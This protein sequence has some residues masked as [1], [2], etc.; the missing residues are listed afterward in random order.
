MRALAAVALLILVSLRASA[1]DSRASSTSTSKQFIV[2]CED[3]AVRGRVTSFVEEV[4]EQVYELLDW[5]DRAQRIPIVV[6]LQPGESP[7][8]VRLF[9]TP[10]GPTIHVDVQVGQNPAD[11]YL[12]KHII[13][14]IMLDF[15]YRGRKPLEA[16]ERYVEAP[17][18]FIYGVIEHQ[19][20]KDLGIDAGFFRNL[21]KNNKMPSIEQFLDGHGLE[22]GATAVAFDSACAFAFVEMLIDQPDGKRRLANFLHSWPDVSNDQVT[23]LTG[24]FPGLGEGAVG[25]QKWWTLN[26]ARFAASDRYLGLSAEDTN[27]ELEKLLEF[28]VVVDKTG[29]AQ[30]FSLS[31]FEEFIKLPG[32][33]IALNNQRAAVLA[34]S[35]HANALFRPVLSAY[36]EI[37]TLLARGRTRSVAQK[38]HG[39]EVYRT[40]ILH[41]MN[42]IEDYLNW[43]EATQ[44]PGSSKPFEN[45]LRTAKEMESK[46][47]QTSNA[48][49]ISDYLDLLEEQLK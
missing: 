8:S 3:A 5:R 28:P 19:R 1:I 35:T 45:Y 15:M 23:A 42:D 17:W 47:Q 4:K 6:T 25:M 26:F 39:V 20:R 2:Y 13:R 9:N 34:L 48:K 30:R 29:R 11:V 12:Q 22:L 37:F 10:D 40:T 44:L 43:Y 14:A 49:A 27:R 31:R 21:V 41:R 32:A 18:W 46:P 33:K 36:D 38:I 7:V 24:A 16:G